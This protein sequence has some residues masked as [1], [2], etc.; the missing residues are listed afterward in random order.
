MFAFRP[1]LFRPYGAIVISPLWGCTPSEADDCAPSEVEVCAPS[2]A[3]VCAPSEA[4]E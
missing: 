1:Y 2:D 3:E 4:E